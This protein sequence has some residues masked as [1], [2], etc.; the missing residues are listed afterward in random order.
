MIRVRC[1]IGTR[2]NPVLPVTVGAHGRFALAGG[3]GFPMDARFKLFQDIVMA[4]PAEGW[5]LGT[6]WKCRFDM[7]DL[8]DVAV[9][10]DTAILSVDGMREFFSVEVRM[11]A[12]TV[13]V[14]DVR[15]LR[16][17]SER[18]RLEEEKEG[19]GQAACGS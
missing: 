4:P 15:R 10:G 18:R 1:R 11:T 14:G 2:K 6:R 16:G 8:R 9:A 17:L 12:K 13:F 5:D 7:R 3:D 19:G